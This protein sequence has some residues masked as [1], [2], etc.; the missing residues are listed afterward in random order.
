VWGSS[1][2]QKEEK[3]FEPGWGNI[4]S[5]SRDEKP[6]GWDEGD[7]QEKPAKFGRGNGGG[8]YG[9]GRDYNGGGGNYRGGG[10]DNYGGGV[11]ISDLSNSKSFSVREE[12]AVI[13]D[14]RPGIIRD[15]SD[16]ADLYHYFGTGYGDNGRPRTF[17]RPRK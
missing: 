11:S 16:R 10:R 1:S 12:A 17:G 6:S 9:G 2:V 4:P 14:K 3:P 8:S 13:D 5:S 15:R 7:G